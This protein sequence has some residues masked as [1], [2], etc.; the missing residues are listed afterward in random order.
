MIIK[1][2]T[3]LGVQETALKWLSFYLGDQSQV[4]EIKQ[5]VNGKLETKGLRMLLMRSAT[6]ACF[7]TNL[8]LFCNDLLGYL[9]LYSHTVMYTEDTV[10]LASR[11]AVK[12]IE[13]NAY[14]AYAWPLTFVTQII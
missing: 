7:R 2:L 14:I 6:R 8:F 3:Y 12:E 1:K 9:E 13:I 5:I 10:T 11:C 4:V